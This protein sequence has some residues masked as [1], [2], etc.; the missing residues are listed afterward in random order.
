[1]VL[2]L[3]YM[4]KPIYGGWVS[5]TAHMA[6]KYGFKIYKVSKRTEFL[7]DGKPRMRSYGYGTYYQNM[8]LED[9]KS[10]PN[11]LITA[12]DKNYYDV[13][14][15]LYTLRKNIKIVIH[16]PTEVKGK[17]CQAV[18]DV[19]KNCKVITIRQSVKQYLLEKY[20]IRSTFKYHPFYEYPIETSKH[21]DGCVSISRIDFDKHTEVLIKAND[22]LKSG[23]ID[24]YGA[25]NDRFVYFKLNKMGMNLNKYYKGTFKKDFTILS[26]I[27]D[28]VKFVID[29]SIIKN[30]GGGSQY[31]FLE[32]LHQ[33]CILIL[34]EDWVKTNKTVFRNGYNCLTVAN[35]QD[36][37]D[38]LKNQKDID[39]SNLLKHS[40]KILEPHLKVSWNI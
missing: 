16:D 4:A 7:K 34:H 18:L 8:S 26:K 37:V 5:F 17:S 28:P 36:I 22:L 31:T 23:H 13:L 27:L 15:K 9:I 30:D 21:K 11:I 29:L 40:S 10:L 14:T 1:M 19:I 39:I 24:I 38:I 12:I 33:K 32:A 2:S 3:V 35:E 25:K 6:L 20:N